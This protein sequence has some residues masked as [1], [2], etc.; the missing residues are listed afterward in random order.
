HGGLTVTIAES[1]QVSQPNAFAGGNTVVTPKSNVKVTQSDS[2]MFMF[3]PGT[4]LDEL[5]RAVNMVGAAPSDVF[6]ILES[7]KVAWAFNCHLIVI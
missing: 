4:T 5:V 3:N 6:S 1:P 7:L 2:R